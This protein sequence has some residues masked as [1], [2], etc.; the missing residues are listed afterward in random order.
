MAAPNV[1]RGTTL[2]PRQLEVARLMAA[3]MT[4][5]QIAARLSLSVRTVECHLWAAYAKTST[6]TRVLLANWL[7][8]NTTVA[9]GL[10]AAQAAP[11]T[12][13][14]IATGI[15]R[16]APRPRSYRLAPSPRMR[17]RLGARAVRANVG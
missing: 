10:A 8:E 11:G 7:S 5:R 1:T 14:G 4:S 9:A 13:S 3:G 2:T 12:R 16:I 17:S 6:G 15:Q